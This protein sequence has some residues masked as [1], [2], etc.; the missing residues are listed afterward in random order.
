MGVKVVLGSLIPRVFGL[1]R[2]ATSILRQVNTEKPIIG[3]PQKPTTRDVIYS[4]I[5]LLKN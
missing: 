3:G 1:F 4:I 5:E 2:S